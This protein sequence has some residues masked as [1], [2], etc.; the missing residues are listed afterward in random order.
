MIER[1]RTLFSASLI[2]HSFSRISTCRSLW[3][4]FPWSKHKETYK[5]LDRQWPQ[6][7]EPY[8]KE[9]ILEYCEVCEDLI[10]HLQ[11]HT[12]ELCERLGA[13]GDV[14][15]GWVGQKPRD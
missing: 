9:D 14:E 8:S 2:M 7:W 12:G 5:A 1:T 10:E 11:Q 13:K 4:T 15:V 3:R 6:G